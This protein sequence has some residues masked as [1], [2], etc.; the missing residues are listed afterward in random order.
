MTSP[1]QAIIT[2]DALTLLVYQT[3]GIAAAIEELAQWVASQG[4]TTAATNALD[5]LRVLDTNAKDLST[6]I[7]ALRQV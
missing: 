4:G 1:N 6:A 5:A 3:H 2:A 7:D